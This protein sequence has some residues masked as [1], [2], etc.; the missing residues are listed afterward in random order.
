MSDSKERFTA[1]ADDYVRARPT[2]AP[3]IIAT[4]LA[5]FHVPQVADLGAGTGISSVQLADAGAVV[6]AIEPNA[7]MRAEIPDHVRVRVLDGTAEST[8]LDDAA[9]DIICACQAYHWFEPSAVFA[10]AARIAKMRARFAAVWNHRDLDDPFTGAFER[11]IDRFDESSG[12]LDR[13]RRATTVGHDLQE[14]GWN[15]VRV[16]EARHRKRY[17]WDVLV[18]YLR[19]ASYLPQSGARYDEM[20][21]DMRVLFDRTAAN[22]AVHVQF[23]SKAHLGER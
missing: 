21:A 15:N 22:G 3:E 20:L 4:V 12:A 9:I 10:E 23:V 7:R 6:I 13:Q 17:E 14:F 1:R 11:V 8:G 18:A 2:Y 16:V 19:S 5:D